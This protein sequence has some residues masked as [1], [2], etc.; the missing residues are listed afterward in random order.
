MCLYIVTFLASIYG[1]VFNVYSYLQARTASEVVE[2][3]RASVLMTLEQD[4]QTLSDVVFGSQGLQVKLATMERTLINGT[5]TGNVSCWYICYLHTKSLTLMIF[6]GVVTK[7]FVKTGGVI[8]SLH[9][10]MFLCGT[11]QLQVN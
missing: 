1:C 3:F 6:L 2:R 8:M 11:N 7:Q 4:V 9:L 10:S 5:V